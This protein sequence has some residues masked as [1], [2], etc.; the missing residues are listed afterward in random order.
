MKKNTFESVLMRW[1]NLEPVIQSKVSQ[2]VKDKHCI[3]MY[4]YGIQKDGTEEITWRAAMENQTQRT[5][6]GAWQGEG[7]G[8][9]YRESNTETSI[10]ICK[11]DSQWEFDVSLRE[12]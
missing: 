7:E 8:K 5:D 10:T 6:L 1:L 11:I 3:L 4:I 9:L 2:K 12:L